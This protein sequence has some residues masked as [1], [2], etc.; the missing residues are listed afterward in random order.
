MLTVYLSADDRLPPFR[1][2][3]EAA[4]DDH[5]CFS[6]LTD[7]WSFSIIFGNTP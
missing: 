6:A 4:S 1:G 5:Y 7:Q 2:Q 3:D